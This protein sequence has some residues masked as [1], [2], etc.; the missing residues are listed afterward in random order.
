[1]NSG[2]HK[3]KE[4]EKKQKRIA[5]IKLGTIILVL[6]AI[7]CYE[8]FFHPE[9]IDL[10][11]SPRT[12]MNSIA[13]YKAFSVPIY[14]GANILQVVCSLPGQ[15]FHLAGG[16]LFGF[17]LGLLLSFVGVT[18]GAAC[19]YFIASK[20]GHDAVFTLFGEKKV[21]QLLEQLNSKKGII[22]LFV[23]YLIPGMPKDLINY[24]AGLSGI[25]FR[26]YIILCMCGRL[27]GMMASLIIGN[28]V[29]DGQYTSA[30]IIA[31]CVLAACAAALIFRKQIIDLF[32][33]FYDKFI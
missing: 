8:Y 12:L 33:K 21:T 24:V 20:L 28:Q 31:A 7:P 17:W 10:V 25:K 23:G 9:L 3:S 30:V 11:K 19:A 1:M 18:I 22:V 29:F 32:G 14:I 4:Y 13:G 16:Y 2:N 27:P 5:R 26:P 6:I 15:V